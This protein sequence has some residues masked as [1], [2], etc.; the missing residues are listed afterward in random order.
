[1]LLTSMYCHSLQCTGE[2]YQV[3]E[4]GHEEWFIGG[5]H[6]AAMYP[7]CP[8]C[9]INLQDCPPP[10]NLTPIMLEYLYGLD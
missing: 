7:C 10:L 5:Y 6:V 9:G 3:T 1:M 8:G 2:V 4:V